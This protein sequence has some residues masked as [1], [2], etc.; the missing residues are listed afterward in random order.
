MIILAAVMML[1]GSLFCFIAALGIVRF[2]DLYT[3]L[4]GAAKAGPIGAGLIL[5]G[6]GVASGE[7][8]TL[9]RAG[10]G[11]LF[12]VLTTPIAAH[13]LARAAIKAHAPEPSIVSIDELHSPRDSVPE[14][15]P[16]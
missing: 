9:L 10:L 16:G 14:Q 1:V 2:P 4:H 12:L 3:R 15:K 13:L 6:A 11:L 5:L 8:Y 7:A